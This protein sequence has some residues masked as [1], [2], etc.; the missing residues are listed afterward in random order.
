MEPEWKRKKKAKAYRKISCFMDQ[1]APLAKIYSW[2]NSTPWYG[3]YPR[4]GNRY[5]THKL[6]LPIIYVHDVFFFL[7]IEFLNKY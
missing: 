6:T 1:T 3:K 2:R 5:F 7:K 4:S